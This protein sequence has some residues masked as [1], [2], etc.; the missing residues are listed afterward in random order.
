MSMDWNY[1]KIHYCIELKKIFADRT[2]INF[3]VTDP[4]YLGQNFVEWHFL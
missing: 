4:S 2:M 3:R 1:V